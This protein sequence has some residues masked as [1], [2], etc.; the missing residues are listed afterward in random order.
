[1]LEFYTSSNSPNYESNI[2]WGAPTLLAAYGFP[3]LRASSTSALMILSLGPVPLIDPK[4]TPDS[5]AIFFANGDTKILSP[6]VRDW[7]AGSANDCYFWGAAC[8][9]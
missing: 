1:M 9:Y 3:D 6:D 8:V 5:S 2:I 7:N 4:S